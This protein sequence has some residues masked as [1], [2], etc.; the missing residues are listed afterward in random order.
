[1]PLTGFLEEECEDGRNYDRGDEDAVGL[2]LKTPSESAAP[3]A[4]FCSIQP[5]AGLP[6]RLMTKTRKFHRARGTAFA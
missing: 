4:S 3:P 6:A 5:N 2:S 1:V